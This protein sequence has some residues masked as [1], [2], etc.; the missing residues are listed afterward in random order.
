MNVKSKALLMLLASTS[1]LTAVISAPQMVSAEQPDETM[2]LFYPLTDAAKARKK[3]ARASLEIAKQTKTSADIQKAALDFANI[4]DDNNLQDNIGVD[5]NVEVHAIFNGIRDVIYSVPDVGTQKKLLIYFQSAMAVARTNESEQG[6]TLYMNRV[7]EDN[8]YDDIHEKL[9]SIIGEV[10]FYNAFVASKPQMENKGRI[11][12]N[13][14]FVIDDR[15]NFEDVKESPF[16]PVEPEMPAIPSTDFSDLD[17]NKVDESSL[18]PQDGTTWEDITYE[19]KDGKRIKKTTTYTMVDGKVVANITE[20]EEGKASFIISTPD[21]EKEFEGGVA[22]NT[23][24]DKEKEQRE[25]ENEQKQSNLTL[26]YTVTKGET[27]AYYYDTGIRVTTEGVATYQQMHDVLYQLA[28]RAEGYLVEDANKLL[29]VAEGKPLFITEKKQ[30]YNKMEVEAMFHSFEKLEIRIMETRIGKTA[31]LEEQIVT[32]KAQ[33]VSLDGEALELKT[34]PAIQE[35]RIVLGI[36]E[37]A[38]LIGATVKLE[39]KKLI[40]N[41]DEAIVVFEEGVKSVLVN[42]SLIETTLPATEKDSV[43]MG[44]V[45]EML[46]AFGVEKAWDEE[47]STL[48][49]TRTT[50]E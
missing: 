15:Y 25:T 24:I 45:T 14:E 19:I 12:S 44:D 17:D 3:E 13:G 8:K 11:D 34:K 30:S 31:S 21:W 36:R 10:M 22:I 9:N 37:M 33:S 46:K 2:T 43:L 29:V 38:E 28:I 6:Y 7:L 40:A 4:L 27:D 16:E 50:K 20:T 32:G 35:G 47:S 5:Y 1:V 18:L 42:G 41:L 49:L 39:D 23:E 48:I 26:Q